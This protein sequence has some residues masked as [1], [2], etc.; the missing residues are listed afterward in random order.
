MQHKVLRRAPSTWLTPWTGR[1]N[2]GLPKL[3]IL[4]FD[5]QYEYRLWKC[6]LTILVT[7]W[8][9]KQ[10]VSEIE[11]KLPQG[12]LWQPS[13]YSVILICNSRTA[14]PTEVLMPFLSFSDNLLQDTYIIF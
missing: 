11:E 6:G 7:F 14:W 12:L 10:E 2:A 3:K 13:V 5:I 9:L 4:I 1:I 8:S